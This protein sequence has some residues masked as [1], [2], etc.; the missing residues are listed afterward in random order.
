MEISF[1]CSCIVLQIERISTW[2]VVHK[3]SSW[4]VKNNLEMA[5]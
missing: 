3:A 2:K 4:E 5:Y 1:S